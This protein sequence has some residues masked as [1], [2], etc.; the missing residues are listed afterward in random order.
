MK[1]LEEVLFDMVD[2]CTADRLDY[3]V[4]GGIAVRIHG[5]PRPTYDVDVT[6]A[7]SSAE[8][9]ALFEGLEARG[10]TVP[11]VYRAGWQDRVADMPI[12]KVRCFLE[13]GFGIDVDLF[14]AETE[15]QKALLQRTVDAEYQG[16]SIKVVSPEDLIL[17]K[18]LA[19]RPRDLGDIQDILFTQGS[20]DI[21][22]M[23]QWAQRLGIADAL[24]KALKD[25][26]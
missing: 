20:L 24:E 22:Y 13:E 3:A 11:Q 10:Y 21:T 15:F 14:L 18:L 19:S 25:C 26:P 7:A 12:V 2:L 23:R 17:L 1:T 16:R 9:N 5:I 8:L 4:M 6:I